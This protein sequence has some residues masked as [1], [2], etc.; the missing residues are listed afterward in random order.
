[1]LLVT[2]ANILDANTAEFRIVQC[3]RVTGIFLAE[4][5][6]GGK[7]CCVL[8]YVYGAYFLL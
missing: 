6:G 8:V 3:N 2:H 4:K 7:A 5:S 1:L